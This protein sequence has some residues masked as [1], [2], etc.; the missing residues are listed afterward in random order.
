MAKRAKN[1]FTFAGERKQCTYTFSQF[2]YTVCRFLTSNSDINNV[3]ILEK[4]SACL[5]V[6]NFH[7]NSLEIRSANILMVIMGFSRLCCCVLFL[8]LKHFASHFLILKKNTHTAHHLHKQ[9]SNDRMKIQE[10][11]K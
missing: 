3:P 9:G 8:I 2:D 5:F 10:F 7:S 11:S 1:T 6:C 4:I